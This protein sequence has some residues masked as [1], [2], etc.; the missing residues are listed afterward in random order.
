VRARLVLAVACAL[1]AAGGAVGQLS[2][3]GDRVAVADVPAGGP[4]Y[5]IYPAPAGLG[6][7]AG[8]PSIGFNPKT[9]A[10]MFLA[11]QSTLRVT[12]DEASQPPTAT[13]A[14]AADVKTDATTLDPILHTDPVTG[15]TF[16]SQLSAGCSFMAFSDDDGRSWTENPIGCGLA[17]GFDHQTVGTAPRTAADP[18]TP[19]LYP[20]LVIYCAQ[21]AA[22]GDCSIS[23]DGGLTYGPQIRAYNTAVDNC[24]GIH[25]HI[26]SAADGTLYLPVRYCADGTGAEHPG[27]AVSEDGGLTWRLSRLDKH[28][29]GGQGDPAVGVGADGTLYFASAS[30]ISPAKRYDATKIEVSVSR[31]KGKTWTGPVDLSTPVGLKNVEFPLAIAGDGDRATVGWIGTTSAGNDSN[32]DGAKPFKGN[33]ALYLS[34]TYDRGATWTTVNATGADPVQRGGVYRAAGAD[35][36]TSSSCRN[37]LDFTEIT[38]DDKGRALVAFADGCVAACVATDNRTLSRAKK[39]TIARQTGGR[40]LYA[41]FD[42]ELAPAVPAAPA[43]PPAAPPAPPADQAPPTSVPPRARLTTVVTGRRIRAGARTVVVRVGATG[44]LRGVVVELRA[45]SRR[46]RVVARARRPTLAGTG[47]VRLHPARPLARGTYWLIVRTATSS[48]VRRLVVR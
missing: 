36:D 17:A 34:T 43:P 35:S 9:K 25:G 27:L 39:A 15:R 13:W 46:G 18:V 42:A 37:M 22:D 48:A 4:S 44:R 1:V 32:C 33:W 41:R 20:R 40:S 8:E 38:L 12:F 24:S 19:G 31:D 21:A 6:E 5:T 47:V 26:K 2:A 16:V 3:G 23:R 45:R 10:V 29:A 14:A 28:I 30:A 11:N 7:S